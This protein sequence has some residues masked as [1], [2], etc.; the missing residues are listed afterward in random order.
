[1]SEIVSDIA[2]ESREFVAEEPATVAI[3]TPERV[4]GT[5]GHSGVG[6]LTTS[7]KL[8]VLGRAVRPVSSWDSLLCFFAEQPASHLPVGST[9][10]MPRGGT[11]LDHQAALRFPGQLPA[12]HD[13][14]PF[15]DGD[16]EAGRYST[17]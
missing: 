4:T 2:N 14:G 15:G 6:V 7:W 16:L 9:L 11:P 10:E 12:R 1:M 5:A 13:S 8:G 3:V 17:Q